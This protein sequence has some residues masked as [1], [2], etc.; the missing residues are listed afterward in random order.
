MEDDIIANETVKSIRNGCFLAMAR[1]LTLEQRIVFSLAE[2]FEISLDEISDIL[3]ISI[4]AVKG[5]LFRARK[6]IFNFFTDRS[7]F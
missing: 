5:L 2:M 6:N 4:P 3:N 7:Q 1:K